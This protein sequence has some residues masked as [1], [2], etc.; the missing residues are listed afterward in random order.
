MAQTPSQKTMTAIVCR[1]PKDYR[2]EKLP[3]PVPRARAGHPY[4]RVR[5]LR[6]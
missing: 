1:G 3:R 2:V 6:E 5:H 4:W